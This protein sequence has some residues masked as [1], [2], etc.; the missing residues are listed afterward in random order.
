MKLY[1]RSIQGF[2][3]GYIYK[4]YEEYLKGDQVCYIPEFATELDT[5]TEE[6]ARE[7]GY[8]RFQL[9]ELCAPYDIDT[10]Y[11]FELLDWQSP[12]TLIDELASYDHE[13]YENEGEE[14]VETS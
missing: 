12:E 6:E 1:E 10:D 7:V 4:S 13:D 8:T 5:L 2:N 9:E 11:L 3:G 14:H